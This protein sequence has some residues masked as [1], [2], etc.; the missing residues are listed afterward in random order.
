MRVGG[1]NY[2]EP[3]SRLETWVSGKLLS[4]QDHRPVLRLSRFGAFDNVDAFAAKA[5][6]MTRKRND[7]GMETGG[8]WQG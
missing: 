2:T 8:Y 3:D 6:A 1:I 7:E 4:M 5:L